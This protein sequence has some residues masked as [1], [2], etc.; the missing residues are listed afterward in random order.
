M[1]EP[2]WVHIKPGDIIECGDGPSLHRWEVQGV[3]LGAL[4]VESLI[5]MESRT[6]KPGWTGEWE[7]HP[8]VFVPAILLRD[9]VRVIPRKV[10]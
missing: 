5:E 2:S 8:R 6:H 9:N 3:H 7:Y 4:G 1:S 10:L